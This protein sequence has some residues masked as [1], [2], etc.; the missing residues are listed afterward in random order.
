MDEELGSDAFVRV[1]EQVEDGS[2]AID[3]VHG[4]RAHGDIEPTILLIN[5]RALVPRTENISTGNR[6]TPRGGHAGLQ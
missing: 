6:M 4:G 5:G 3:T 2:P 1:A